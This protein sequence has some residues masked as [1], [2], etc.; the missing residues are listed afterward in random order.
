M[1]VFFVKLLLIYFY[2]VAFSSQISHGEFFFRFH[3]AAF[4]FH[5]LERLEKLETEVLVARWWRSWRDGKLICVWMRVYGKI[6]IHK[7]WGMLIEMRCCMYF[8]SS[9]SYGKKKFECVYLWCCT[10]SSAIFLRFLLLFASNYIE[11]QRLTC[12]ILIL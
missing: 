8:M 6:A 11:G 3:Q 1:A 5:F 4:F 9:A 2:A 12:F 10:T 7:C